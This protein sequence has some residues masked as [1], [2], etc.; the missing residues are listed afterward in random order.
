MT[1]RVAN[2]IDGAYWQ[3]IVAGEFNR[4]RIDFGALA[5]AMA[6]GSSILRTYYYHCMP[7][8]SSRPSREESERYAASQRFYTALELLPRFEVRLGRL[9]FRGN[10]SDGS[11][12]LEQKRVDIML[13]V[14][15][16]QLA[17]KG[18]ITQ[19][20]LLA[21]DSDFIPAVAVAKAEGVLVRLFHGNG[22]HADLLRE[23]DERVKFD[24]AL[25]DLVMLR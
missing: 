21:G 9:E 6:N 16:V 18:H 13:G 22:C 10:R 25:V 1:E 4:A 20:N 23:V 3:R 12:I 24:Q 7:Y 15:M 2:F 19:A 5:Q 17:A 11:P 14:D 8:Q